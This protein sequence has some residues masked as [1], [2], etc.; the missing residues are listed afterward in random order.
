VPRTAHIT[1][2]VP[3]GGFYRYKTNSNMT[4]SWLIG[5]SMKVVR[6]LGDAEVERLNREIN[7]AAD[8]PRQKP[9]DAAKYGFES[10]VFTSVV[11]DRQASPGAKLQKDFSPHGNSRVSQGHAILKTAPIN[12]NQQEI[13]ASLESMRADAAMFKKNMDV[14]RNFKMFANS[15]VDGMTDEQVA[16][17]FIEHVRD[18]LVWLANKFEE[19]HPGMRERAKLWYIG[20]NKIAGALGKK[21]KITTEQAAAVLATQSPQKDWFQNISLAERI[22]A[23]HKDKQAQD[24]TERMTALETK[25]FENKDEHQ[26]LLKAIKGKRLGDL[27]TLLERAAW[28]RLYDEAEN[29][30]A[31]AAV[32]P[33]GDVV[34]VQTKKDGAPGT[35]AW[36]GFSTIAKSLSILDDGSFENV[37]N[38]LGG[39]HKVRNF[40]NNIVAPNAM[41]GDVTIDTHA[42]AAAWLMPMSASSIEVAQNF[43]TSGKPTKPEK[44]ASQKR[45][46]A[47]KR[48]LDRW[49]SETDFGRLTTSSSGK[50]GF[51]GL[52]GLY[53]DAYR[54]AAAQAGV[55]PREMQSITWEAVRGLFEKTQKG[56]NKSLD[57]DVQGAWGDFHES[58]DGDIN[59]TREAVLQLAGGIAAPVWSRGSA[60]RGV[61]G[62][63]EFAS[64]GT[65]LLE[66]DL[67]RP[68]KSV[69]RGADGA[70]RAVEEEALD[71]EPS[72]SVTDNLADWH[73]NQAQDR[74]TIERNRRKRENVEAWVKG[75]DGVEVYDT[76]ADFPFDVEP[77]VRAAA[78]K[79]RVYIAASEFSSKA[80]VRD[81][82]AH[83]MVGHLKAEMVPGYFPLLSDIMDDASRVGVVKQVWDTEQAKRPWAGKE[84]LARETI[85]VMAGRQSK[86]P[87]IRRLVN[88]YRKLLLTLGA[89]DPTEAKIYDLIERAY[90]EKNVTNDNQAWFSVANKLSYQA[91]MR[92]VDDTL[93]MGIAED[94]MGAD[95][96]KVRRE[97]KLER[98]R[99]VYEVEDL[100]DTYVQPMEAARA[101]AG[102]A[103]EQVS[104][105]LHARHA[106]EANASLRRRNIARMIKEGALPSNVDPERIP[107]SQVQPLIQGPQAAYWNEL[108]EAPAGMTDQDA[109]DILREFSGD[110]DMQQIGNLADQLSEHKLSLMVSS[111]LLSQVK[112]DVFR[113]AYRHYVPLFRDL[114]EQAPVDVGLS[115][116]KGGRQGSPGRVRKGSTKNVL[117]V[118]AQLINE[119]QR[120]VMTASKQKVFT[121]FLGEVR[122]HPGNG[123]FQ[124]N[125]TQET[126]TL[127]AAGNIVTKDTLIQDPNLV[128][129]GYENGKRVNIVA[130]D[131]PVARNA[132]GVWNRIGYRDLN[133]FSA[134]IA[135]L[136][137]FFSKMYTSMSVNF[138]VA[139]P[140]RDMMTALANV[141]GEEVGGAV[142]GR[143]KILG[144]WMTAFTQILASELGYKNTRFGRVFEEMGRTG[145]RMAWLEVFPDEADKSLVAIQRKYGHKYVVTDQGIK[146]MVGSA[147]GSVWAGIEYPFKLIGTATENA[148]RAVVWDAAVRAG[149]DKGLGIEEAEKSASKLSREVT[150]DFLSHGTMSQSLNA[151]YLFFNP[152]IQGTAK[153]V[154]RLREAPGSTLA[155][156]GGLIMTSFMIDQL[157]RELS[158]D[159]DEDGISNYDEA[160]VTRTKDRNLV[161]PV[162]KEVYT[163]K[164]GRQAYITLPV[165]YYFNA[166]T[167]MGQALSEAFSGAKMPEAGPEAIRNSAFRSAQRVINTAFTSLSPFGGF[168]GGATQF[169]APTIG[170]LF[171]QVAS[172]QDAFGNPIHPE[173][174]GFWDTRQQYELSFK[175]TPE[176]Y[177]SAGKFV[178]HML[179]GDEHQARFANALG[180]EALTNP[181]VLQHLAHTFGGGPVALVESTMK[182]VGED[183][184]PNNIVGLSRFFKA[185][186]TDTDFNSKW[187][188]VSDMMG[189]HTRRIEALDGVDLARF[190]SKNPEARL[191][192][193]FKELESSVKKLK[194]L[195]KK[196][197][198]EQAQ[199]VEDRVYELQMEFLRKYN[200]ATE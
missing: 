101:R 54:E 53:A 155:I 116:R 62:Q 148:T 29:S 99:V 125:E 63:G 152:A 90:R 102:F 58:T 37:S 50:H 118:Y 105:F 100:L 170:D 134:R 177:K 13:S 4:G 48:K 166:F 9:F 85:A 89:I 80:E 25:V 178:H 36:Q 161:M 19:Q 139:N 151:W 5:G 183:G 110:P 30:Y 42:V 34:G 157:A 32:S 195:A 65:E 198:P 59:A 52:Y 181:E 200:Q 35:V 44:G 8:L 81:E 77:G 43:G 185:P 49:N 149:L 165:A 192:A 154:R 173:P 66:P 184:S 190:L 160:S 16:R 95:G 15:E 144:N 117:N 107:L 180:I 103:T 108:W 106:I 175:K 3:L 22:I 189:E 164:D 26:A 159:D 47:Y 137:R 140:A 182:A 10:D 56:G 136:G 55:L 197:T 169:A 61:S 39:E 128:I 69:R 146:R 98:S 1:D 193:E 2:Q 91:Q 194:G 153:A 57:G 187:Y 112:A 21:Y 72:F 64:Y 68:G 18:N 97:I 11:P 150:A 24:Y 115:S 73:A 162:P 114:G 188:P 133:F 122:A 71:D 33:E 28:V 86:H 121:Q 23:I 88:A 168:E 14:V 167:V 92:F 127:D 38:M 126:V 196:G 83:E 186:Q 67:R 12:S 120:T 20:A 51:S 27:D 158:D 96:Q 145:G 79:G 179:G 163:T 191:A 31:Y 130:S 131:D 109:A 82:Y 156:Y 147:A 104:K 60:G 17:R 129:S 124:I 135:M 94:D 78:W 123:L 45:W 172:N 199:A 7:G 46:D 143:A 174:S 132:V 176:F 141:K 40:Y 138:L 41:S 111:G 75:M 6:L 119:A 74:E 113:N 93:A 87:L 142:S 84:E 70:T 76:P 171:V